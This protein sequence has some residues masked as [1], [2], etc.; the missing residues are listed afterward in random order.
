VTF[1]LLAVIGGAAPAA[2]QAATGTRPKSFALA[3][4]L[5]EQLLASRSATATLEDYQRAMCGMP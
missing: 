4:T 5:N 3:Q 1:A 2:R